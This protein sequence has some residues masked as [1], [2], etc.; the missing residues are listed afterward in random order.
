MAKVLKMPKREYRDEKGLTRI[1]ELLSSE[2]SEEQVANAKIE[3]WLKLADAALT[4]DEAARI[5][6][7]SRFRE[8][9]VR[10]RRP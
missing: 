3:K 9:R 5:E 8:R 1:P 2:I 7:P 10:P 6:F 4:P